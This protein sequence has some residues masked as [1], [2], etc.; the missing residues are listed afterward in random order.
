MKF[1]QRFSGWMLNVFFLEFLLLCL[2]GSALRA[3]DSPSPAAA[4]WLE[5]H[6]RDAWDL[7]ALVPTLT[8]PDAAFAFVRDYIA[9]EPYLGVMKGAAGTL[10]TRGGNDI[11]RALLLAHLLAAQGLE[12]HLVRG[13][14][15]PPVA[16]NVPRPDSV[17]QLLAALP[18]PQASPSPT[19]DEDR[20]N[21]ETFRRAAA[22]R[23]GELRLN[24]ERAAAII[25]HA[26]N[27][28]P[29]TLSSPAI[30]ETHVWVQA[31]IDGKTVDFDPATPSAKSGTAPGKATESWAPDAL[32]DD[33]PQTFSFRLIAERLDQGQLKAEPLLSRDFKV[34]D[35]FQTGIRLAIVPRLSGAEAGNLQP[36]MFVGDDTTE[37]STFRVSGAVAKAPEPAGAGGLLGGFG[38]G[39]EPETKPAN[40]APLAR[41]VVQIV[42]HAP[43]LK[44]ETL[45]RTILDRVEQKNGHWQ[46]QSAFTNEDRVRLLLVQTWDLGV[47]IGAIHPLALFA[48]QAAAVNALSPVQTAVAEGRPPE[49]AG[50]L[51]TAPQLQG[52]FFNSGL[53]RHEI[54][55]KFGTRATLLRPRLAFLRHGMA[56]ADWTRPDGPL[57]YRE[58]ID[59]LNAPLAMAGSS[60]KDAEA[61]WRIGLSDTALEQFVLHRQATW[62]TLPI[63]AA[64]H[65][66]GVEIVTLAATADLD[67]VSVAPGI[68]AVLAQDL[69][70][71]HR[72]IGP[73]RPAT[74]GSGHAYAWWSVDSATGYITGRVDLGGAQGLAEA[75]EINEKITEWT[76]N[77]VKF[78]GNVLKCYTTAIAGSLGSVNS[79]FDDVEGAVTINHGSDPSPDKDKLIDCLKDAVC[80]ALKDFVQTEINSA[81]IASEHKNLEEILN[82]FAGEQLA[83]QG[84]GG[85]IGASCGKLLGG[86][87]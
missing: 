56:I 5:A 29:L 80:D 86:E 54:A 69:A 14:I 2:L 84:A 53:R 52:Y 87:K 13:A 27:A 72:L 17:D 15:K 10:L 28:V 35:S 49:A 6:P 22:D 26:L 57:R 75:E 50:A 11:D 48:A 41:L 73:V 23:A 9:I 21:R 61:A 63:L 45:R 18:S 74:F 12:V 83:K 43:G 30:A 70:D 7:E 4:A 58:G 31:E 8:T 68:R 1:D 19:S 44:N 78:L 65:D 62:N 55:A 20:Q 34:A 67:R 39:D 76:E 40:V 81:A 24:E 25:A 82:E 64:A 59:L 51:A 32:P 36:K 46:I 79:N 16:E 60:A 85:G 3:D 38:G 33:L 37:G 66:Q 42:L 77:Y 47:D 71:G